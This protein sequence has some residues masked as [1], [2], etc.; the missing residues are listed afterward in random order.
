MSEFRQELKEICDHEWGK[1][2]AGQFFK[3]V[4]EDISEELYISAMVQ[5]FHYTKN[6]AINQAAACFPDDHKKVGLLRFAMKHALEEVG[7]ENMVVNDHC[8]NG[9]R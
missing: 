5:V 1:I 3:L 2:K 9:C 4:R 6:N 7:H 8:F